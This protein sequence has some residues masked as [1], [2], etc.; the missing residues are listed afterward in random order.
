[1][2]PRQESSPPSAGYPALAG[3]TLATAAAAAAGSLSSPRSRP[4]AHRPPPRWYR[5]LE[6][7]PFQPPP[8]LFGPVWTGLYTLIATSGWRV[9]SSPKS[10]RRRAALALWGTQ[11]ALNGIWPALFFGKRRPRAALVDSALL[12]STSVAYA[13]M[14]RKVDPTSAKLFVPYIGWLAFATLLNAEIVRRNPSV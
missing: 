14:A 10:S 3:F 8:W 4:S 13:R 11:L 7:P 5:R 6:K 12:F 2:L 1:M 9:Y